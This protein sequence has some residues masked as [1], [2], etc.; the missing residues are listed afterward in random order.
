MLHYDALQNGDPP[1]AN[2]K[3]PSNLQAQHL[4]YLEQHPYETYSEEE[5]KKVNILL[6]LL[7]NK[8]ISFCTYI[9]FFVISR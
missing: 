3:T 5:I 2:R 4:A 8:T 7:L 1:A 6:F 9:F